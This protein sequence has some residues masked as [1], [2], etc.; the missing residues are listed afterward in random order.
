MCLKI[1]F[2]QNKLDLKP[3]QDFSPCFGSD[4]IELPAVIHR[5]II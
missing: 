3:I 5:I 1:I 4:I 2:T